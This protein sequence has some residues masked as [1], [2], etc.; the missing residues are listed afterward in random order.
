M[1]TATV[2]KEIFVSTKEIMEET[3]F[4]NLFFYTRSLTINQDYMYSH[5][6]KMFLDCLVK[7][8]EEHGQDT[9]INMQQGSY[10]N[11]FTEII[12]FDVDDLDYFIENCQD[13]DIVKLF[14]NCFTDN[15]FITARINI[16]LNKT[17]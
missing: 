11:E 13:K 17:P 8:R 10:S 4:K 14:N 2:Q 1:S 15:C 6:L 9:R 12:K 5:A 3:K 16:T 7:K